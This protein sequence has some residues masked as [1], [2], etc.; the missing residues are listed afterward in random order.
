MD[1]VS[2]PF[3]GRLLPGEKVVWSG[4]PAT[5][6]ILTPWDVFLIPF[7]LF[8]C[9]FIVFWIAG[10]GLAGGGA[11]ALFGLP[12]LAVGAFI[13]GGRFWLDAW[14]RGGTRYALTNQRVLISRRSPPFNEFTAVSIDRLP[15]ARLSESKGGRGTI[16]F[17]QSMSIFAAGGF[18][19]W[20]PAL[21]NTPRFTAITDARRVFDLVQRSVASR[22]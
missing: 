8:W 3:A 22:P 5:G 16:R 12:F 6:V 4:Q 14:L 1:S 9:G 13:M 10:V 2:D 18:S 21:D 11:F 20:V 15:D 19:M 7:S 17:G